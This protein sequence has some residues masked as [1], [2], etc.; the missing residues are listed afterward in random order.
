MLYVVKG[1]LENTLNYPKS[2]PQEHGFYIQP[3]AVNFTNPAVGD[4]RN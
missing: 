2:D 3:S 4:P 1:T